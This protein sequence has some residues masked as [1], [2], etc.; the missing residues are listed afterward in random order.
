MMSGTKRSAT[1]ASAA[2][3]HLW[4]PKP[5]CPLSLGWDSLPCPSRPPGP[6]NP[7]PGPWS[8]L[9]EPRPASCFLLPYLPS[10]Q[11][12]P[13][14]PTCF[15]WPGWLLRMLKLAGTPRPPR[16]DHNSTLQP[17]PPS[18][19]SLLWA[20]GCPTLHGDLPNGLASRQT[21]ILTSLTPTSHS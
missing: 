11:P 19:A 14:L 21:R 9:A 10:C 4:V 17:P 5:W 18:S 15:I 8:Q 1:Q 20:P 16:P 13:R 6:L 3:S 7:Q 12:P 2:A